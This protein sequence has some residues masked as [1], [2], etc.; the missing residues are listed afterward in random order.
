MF[1]LVKFVI[2]IFIQFNYTFNHNSIPMCSFLFPTTN[3]NK[4]FLKT[5]ACL[6]S[7]NIDMLSI[8]CY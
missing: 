3:Y 4:L 8:S 2:I 1:T 7:R 5:A 6:V